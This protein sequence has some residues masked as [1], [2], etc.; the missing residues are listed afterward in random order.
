M[1]K[2]NCSEPARNRAIEGLLRPFL[3]LIA[4]T[5]QGCARTLTATGPTVAAK[6]VI[7]DKTAQELI[8]YEGD[9][10]FLR[11]RVSTGRMGRR[12]PSGKFTA[13]FKARIHYSRL[14][15]NAPMPFSV[16]VNGNYFIHGFSSVPDRPASHGC[17]RVPLT[18]DNPARRFFEWVEPG[19]P[20]EITGE[21]EP[22][23]PKTRTVR[24]KPPVA[25]PP[26]TPQTSAAA[27][28]R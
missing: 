18:G 19:T 17:I 21:W 10:I 20:I 23:P 25:K 6:R 27:V 22:P 24:P 14:Y 15:D 9:K 12:T 11:T 4:L 26:E 7:V 1:A 13:G 3:L 2:A 5:L 16:Q 8:A 28:P